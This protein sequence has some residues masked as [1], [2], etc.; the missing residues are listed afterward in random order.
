MNDSSET[1][2][3]SVFQPLEAR[4]VLPVPGEVV[5]KGKMALT[6]LD[7]QK[8]DRVAFTEVRLDAIG[9]RPS[10]DVGPSAVTSV[11][12]QWLT[13]GYVLRYHT[14][15]LRGSF[16]KLLAQTFDSIP[17]ALEA[18]A[19]CRE[20]PDE[21]LEH[22]RSYRIRKALG[23]ERSEPE[24]PETQPSEENPGADPETD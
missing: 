17:E 7:G 12:S 21:A 1:E 22:S 16:R 8:P 10:N 11:G 3:P 4:A 19:H 5:A 6:A 20:I 24:E 2:A 18:L 23:P 15:G 13:R 14:R 9:M